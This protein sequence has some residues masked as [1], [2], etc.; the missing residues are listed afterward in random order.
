MTG[1]RDAGRGGLTV[2]VRDHRALEDPRVER[3]EP[4]HVGDIEDRLGSLVAEPEPDADALEE[5]VREAIGVAAGL[6]V[7]LGVER[8]DEATRARAAGS[9]APVAV[10]GEAPE[11]DRSPLPAAGSTPERPRRRGP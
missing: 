10:L 11:L 8:E 5:Q 6:Q 9:R 4:A 3:A 2:G 7:P 1:A